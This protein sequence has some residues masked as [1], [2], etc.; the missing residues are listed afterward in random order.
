MLSITNPSL[1][2]L[3]LL[4]LTFHSMTLWHKNY[5]KK[6]LKLWQ[7]STKSSARNYNLERFLAKESSI[8]LF[9]DFATIFAKKRMTNSMTR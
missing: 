6:H 8:V 1:A 5:S 2:C 9:G 4:P 3:V 7:R